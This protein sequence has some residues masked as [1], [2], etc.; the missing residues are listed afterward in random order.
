MSHK[1]VK[2]VVVRLTS[3]IKRLSS[4]RHDSKREMLKRVEA[5]DILGF[6]KQCVLQ[7]VP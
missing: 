2:K 7:M 6:L 5:I 1:I 3:L 4:G